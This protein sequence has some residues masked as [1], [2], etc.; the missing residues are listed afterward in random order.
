MI[1]D[2]KNLI[3]NYNKINLVP[4]GEFSPVENILNK[5]GLKTITNNIGSFNKGNNRHIIQLKNG[6]KKLNFLSSR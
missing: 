4:F 1:N 2:Y 5:F 6:K 3:D